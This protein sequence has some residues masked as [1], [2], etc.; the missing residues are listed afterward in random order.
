MD[1]VQKAGIKISGVSLRCFT[2]FE[3]TTDPGTYYKITLTIKMR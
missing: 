2:Y 3:G 1:A